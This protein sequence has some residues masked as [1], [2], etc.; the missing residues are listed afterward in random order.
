MNNYSLILLGLMGCIGASITNGLAK[1]VEVFYMGI[2]IDTVAGVLGVALRAA[3][4]QQVDSEEAARA[5]AI[6]GALEGSMYQLFGMFYNFVYNHTMDSYA[7]A[8]YFCS[9]GCYVI[10]LVVG[11][12]L[13][14]IHKRTEKEQETIERPIE[15]GNSVQHENSLDKY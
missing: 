13:R 1:V 6:I 11:V 7:G 2:A 15:E 3:L 14:N 12:V 10:A 8:F 4:M 9:T 5:N